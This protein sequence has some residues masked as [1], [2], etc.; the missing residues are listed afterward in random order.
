MDTTKQWQQLETA[1][2]SANQIS[3]ID[4][5]V[6]LLPKL[7]ELILDCNQIKTISKLNGLPYLRTLSLCENLITECIDCHLELGNLKTLNLSQNQIKSLAGF[8]KMYSLVTLNVSCNIIENIDEVDHIA[9]LPCL[10]ELILTG[11]PVAGVVGEWCFLSRNILF[12][13]YINFLS[14]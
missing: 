9:G 8:R 6:Q 3:A 4:N 14:F 12:Q 11:N 5:S 10:E 7:K 1:D 2:F 13:N